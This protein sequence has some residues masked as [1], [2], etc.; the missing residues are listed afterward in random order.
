MQVRRHQRSDKKVVV[1]VVVEGPR[2]NVSHALQGLLEN[3][4]Y[5]EMVSAIKQLAPSQVVQIAKVCHGRLYQMVLG[6]W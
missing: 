5:N 2:D 6:D 4:D 1:S 3:A